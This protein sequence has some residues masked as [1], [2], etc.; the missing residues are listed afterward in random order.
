MAA[1]AVGG[2]IS[3]ALVTTA[4]GLIIAIPAVVAHSIFTRKIDRCT[5]EMEESATELMEVIK[6]VY[7]ED[8]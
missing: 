4:A 7:R 2:G 6:V 3:E 5:L 1:D 8:R